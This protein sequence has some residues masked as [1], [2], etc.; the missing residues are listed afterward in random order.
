MPEEQLEQQD[1]T[2]V[3]GQPPFPGT[4]STIMPPGQPGVAAEVAPR[5]DAPSRRYG[6]A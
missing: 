2:L 6:R 4:P 5:R 1:G 3:I